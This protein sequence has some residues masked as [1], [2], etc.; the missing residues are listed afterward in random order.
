MSDPHHYALLIGNGLYERDPNKLPR[1]RGPANDLR[2]MREALTH[3]DSGLFDAANV[4]ELLDRTNGEIL[5][6]IE[7]FF[8]GRSRQDTLLLYYSGHGLP[9]NNSN[10][11]LCARNTHP[12][13]L[14]SS[15]IADDSINAMARNSF[16]GKFIFILDC[17]HSGGFKGGAD[18]RKLVAISEDEASRPDRSGRC[19]ITSCASNELSADATDTEGASVFTYHLARA[20]TLP[21][22]DA[23]GDGQVLMSE[24]FKHVEKHVYATSRQTVQY[25]PDRNFGDTPIAKVAPRPRAAD[26]SPIAGVQKPVD[27]SPPP[28]RPVLKVSD[29][30][31]EPPRA[32]VGENLPTERIEIIN[33]GGGVLDWDFEC[34]ESWIG[35]QR[36]GDTLFVTLDTSQPGT[37]RGNIFVRDRGRGGSRTVRVLLQVATPAVPLLIVSRQVVDFGV[38]AQKKAPKFDVRISNGGAGQ[39][40]WTVS[41]DT[42]QLDV[43]V[44]EKGFSVGVASGFVGNISAPLRV[45]S[46]GGEAA[47]EVRG[48]ITPP[49][50]EPPEPPP[51][52]T[53]LDPLSQA[54]LGWWTNDAGALHIK[55]EQGALIYSDHNMMGMQVGQGVIRVQ[56]GFAHLQGNNSFAGN[57]SAQVTIQGAM[58][59]G[60]LQNAFGQLMPVLFMRQQPWFAAFTQ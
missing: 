45:K 19:L 37:R 8:S 51:E 1:L 30:R 12:N 16:A 27:V 26:I 52:P 13:L 39:L 40:Q 42:R 17:C 43:V 11:F 58:L 7:M 15:A 23:D 41:S 44:D 48:T 31:I 47:I 2:L 5:E 38:C 53:P 25:A 49:L 60:Q 34:A 56:G 55:I 9:D 33:D 46:N 28:E 24:V 22:V 21:E 4:T 54:L 36:R 29:E 3:P 32:E 14:T 57:Y 35:I 6:Q 50:P 59:T 18:G 10:L 20:L